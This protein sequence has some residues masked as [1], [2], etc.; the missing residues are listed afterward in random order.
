MLDKN[1]KD[2][3]PAF[4]VVC[5][6]VDAIIDDFAKHNQLTADDNIVIDDKL[7]IHDAG[8]TVAELKEAIGFDDAIVM[9]NG[10]A[11][12]D[13]DVVTNGFTLNIPDL[14]GGNLTYTIVK[15][16]DL[17][18]D[19]YV[20]AVDI[21]RGKKAAAGS[22]EITDVE[23]LAATASRATLTIID[24]AALRDNFMN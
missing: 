20:N 7:V 8:S 18:S 14:R 12:S 1:D 4:D 23:N 24:I 13:N 9:A 10:V 11:L 6:E 15:R 22:V 5:D 2:Y 16:Y 19:G 3:L 17:N 21:V